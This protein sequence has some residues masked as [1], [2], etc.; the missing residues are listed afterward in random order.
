MIFVGLFTEGNTD[1]Q[2]LESIIKKTLDEIA[3]ECTHYIETEIKTISITKTDLSF[4]EQVLAASK[5]GFD[6]YSINLLC[7]HADA[8]DNNPK[9]TYQ[10]RIIPAQNA[11]KAQGEAEYCKILVA[12]VPVQEIESWMLADKE[13]LKRQI[14]TLKTDVQLGIHRLPESVAQPKEVIEKAI[15]IA[16]QDMPKKIQKNLTVAELY[17]LIG[18]AI[19]LKKL[20]TLPSYLL[21][22]EEMRNAFKILNLL[23]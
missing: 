1:T 18:K 7:V 16:R 22:K 11:L 20:E 23:Y 21:F 8:D 9:N 15:R 4:V 17:L 2:F 14:G 19:D 12:I 10:N 5:K 3:F 13:L 6:G